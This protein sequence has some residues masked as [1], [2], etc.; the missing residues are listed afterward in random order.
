MKRISVIVPVYNTEAYV[1]QS[2][3]SILAQTH[4]NLELIL[5]ND[6]STDTSGTICD[7]YAAKDSRVQVVHQNNGGVSHARNI[8]LSKASGDYIAFVDA[9]DSIAPLYL[10]L[11]Y[12]L[13]KN[14]ECNV[15]ICGVTYVYKVERDARIQSYQTEEVEVVSGAE[16]ARRM[17]YQKAINSGPFAKL[18]LKNLFKDINFNEDLAIGEDLEINY[19][20]LLKSDKVAINLSK[21][22]FY[23]QRTGSTMQSSF[24]A[25]RL[26]SIV[27][28]KQILTSAVVEYP[29]LVSSIKNRLFIE[30]VILASEI[31]RKEYNYKADFNEC[32]Q[33]IKSLRL[34]VFTD[35]TSRLRFK[36]YAGVS[37]VNA[38]ALVLF[39]KAKKLPKKLLVKENK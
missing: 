22:Y 13:L 38:H 14:K 19:R 11:L 8:G 10:E 2:I 3:E 5:V 17:L 37:L 15:A 9:D 30:S 16:A 36:V 20:L 34:S 39:F 33:L 25:K 28:L 29:Q 18:F 27:V 32:I 1:A 7:Q 21:N 4:S 31:P 24:S 6:G 35:S 12:G 26:D 23:L